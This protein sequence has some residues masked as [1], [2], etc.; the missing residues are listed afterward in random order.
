M[1]SNLEFLLSQND[2]TKIL[3]SL[4]KESSRNGKIDLVSQFNKLNVSHIF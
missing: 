2:I 3:K 4:N 1:K